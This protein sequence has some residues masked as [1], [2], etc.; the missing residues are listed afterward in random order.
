MHIHG[1]KKTNKQKNKPEDKREGRQ[2]LGG[3]EEFSPRSA[4]VVRV[5]KKNQTESAVGKASSS[6]ASTVE[7]SLKP[8][9]PDW[10]RGLKNVLKK[11]SNYINTLFL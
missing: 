9:N 6:P 8:I 5:F 10:N 4:D 7:I 11:K 1:K 2:A 3:S